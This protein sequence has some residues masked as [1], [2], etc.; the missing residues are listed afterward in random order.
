MQLGQPQPAF[1]NKKKFS[2]TCHQTSDVSDVVWLTGVVFN[3]P[4]V[5]RDVRL[6]Q[7]HTVRE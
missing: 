3:S 2:W 4:V 5:W 6:N 1:A 7:L